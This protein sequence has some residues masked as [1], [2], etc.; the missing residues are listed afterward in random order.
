MDG[1]LTLVELATAPVDEPQSWA[2]LV[3]GVPLIG[4]FARRRAA[5]CAQ[6]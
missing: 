4:W 3:M 5:R 2:L 6:V 1:A